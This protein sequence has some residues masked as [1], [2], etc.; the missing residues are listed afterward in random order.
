MEQFAPDGALAQVLLEGGAGPQVAVVRG[1]E[2]VLPPAPLRGRSLKELLA[3]W[4]VT[5]AYLQ[6]WSPVG[7][8]A[9]AAIEVVAPLTYPDLLL[10][11]GANYVDHLQEMGV[12]VPETPPTPF[13][14]LKP[15]VTSII[16]PGAVVPIPR[17]PDPRLDWEGELAV[18]V[19]HRVRDVPPEEARQHIAGYTVANDVSAR[20]HFR[21]AESLG[22]PFFFDWLAHKGQEGFC[23]LGP[24]L[25]PAWLVPDPQN[26]RLR[27]SVN[28]SVKQS[29]STAD[30]YV[31]IDVLL[32]AAS[33]YLPLSPGDVILTG[34]PSGVG[35]ASGT[36]L[37]AGD[38]VE[39]EIEG[40][41][42]LRNPIGAR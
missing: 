10:C 21:R 14:F 37:S 12:N 8:T 24:A 29:G 41:G 42:T 1:D 7:A 9:L 36:F 34:T 38:E 28:G 27:T 32:S 15:P 35:A 18:V 4:D 2:L 11:A 20:G 26:L 25:M 33:S 16:G 13:F 30:M 31:S 22:G 3:D 6:D 23:P 5:A 40:V 19:A 17:Q 39:I